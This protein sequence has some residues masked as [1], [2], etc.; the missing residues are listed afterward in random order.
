MT[1]YQV[2]FGKVSYHPEEDIIERS[3]YISKELAKEQLET[4]KQRIK[5]VAENLLQSGYYEELNDEEKEKIY[6]K[7]IEKDYYAEI[8][9]L[10]TND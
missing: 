6:N 2:T 8:K 9:E 1:I 4:Y 10:Y 3:Y 7:I 5:N